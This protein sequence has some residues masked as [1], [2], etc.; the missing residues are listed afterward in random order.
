MGQT[1]NIEVIRRVVE[2]FN[3]GHLAAAGLEQPS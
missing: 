2:S 1:E 3:E